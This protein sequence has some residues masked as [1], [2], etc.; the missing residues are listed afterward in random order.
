M[1]E[2]GGEWC[3]TKERGK[4]HQ[5]EP[6]EQGFVGGQL[7]PRHLEMDA[8]R[9]CSFREAVN[10]ILL[11]HHVNRSE[12]G[13]PRLSLVDRHLV[14]K[15]EFQHLFPANSQQLSGKIGPA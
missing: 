4:R 5:L 7:I 3:D 6:V 8:A 14:A 10:A 13:T 15:L 2:F 11:R 12:V 1:A 9:A